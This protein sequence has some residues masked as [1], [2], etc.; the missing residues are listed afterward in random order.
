MLHVSALYYMCFLLGCYMCSES[1]LIVYA[2]LLRIMSLVPLASQ[3]NISLD[4]IALTLDPFMILGFQ[5][6][7]CR[8]KVTFFL[9]GA[10]VHWEFAVRCLT[11]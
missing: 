1:L 3:L 2:I 5:S 10:S 8:M 11:L 7:R 6:H 4:S 9:A